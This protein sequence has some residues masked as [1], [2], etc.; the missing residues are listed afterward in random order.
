MKIVKPLDKK[1][2]ECKIEC[3]DDRA[4]QL[5]FVRWLLSLPSVVEQK[6]AA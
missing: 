5:R 1:Q 3:I 2:V 6:K 4:A